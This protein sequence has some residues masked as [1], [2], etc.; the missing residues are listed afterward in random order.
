MYLCKY[1]LLCALAQNAYRSSASFI[2]RVL[3]KC[4]AGG[5]HQKFVGGTVLNSCM[6]QSVFAAALHE[7]QI[8]HH[9]IP[10]K[11]PIVQTVHGIKC[12]SR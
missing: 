6:C 4:G 3:I 5:A 8:V 9:Q 10:H 11:V 7:D 1:E 2:S 12:E